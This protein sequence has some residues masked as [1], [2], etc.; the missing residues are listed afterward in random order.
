MCANKILS[1]FVVACLTLSFLSCNS[2]QDD[3]LY[4]EAVVIEPAQETTAPVVPAT[5]ETSHSTESVSREI[6]IEPE[7]QPETTEIS[8]IEPD[9][10]V[11]AEESPK[12]KGFL[13]AKGIIQRTAPSIT[14]DANKKFSSTRVL[15]PEKPMIA[16][17]FDDG[18]SDYTEDIVAKL[19][20]YDSAATFFVVG[21]QIQRYTSVLEYIVESGSEIGNHTAAH[22]Y[23]TSLNLYEIDAAI[24]DVQEK[25]YSITGIYP[26]L[27][28]PPYGSVNGFVEE[29]VMFPLILWSVDTLDWLYKDPQRI[30]DYIMENASD[31]A[32]ILMHDSKETTKEAVLITIEKLISEGFQLVTVSELFEAKNIPL[33]AGNVYRS[34]K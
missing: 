5:S 15:D 2:S 8:P 11:I 4:R 13:Y 17:T 10:P 32:V 30:S 6:F 28:R 1:F 21:T 22:A 33:E 19:N 3:V 26:T 31:S 9:A 34:A 14:D 25:V 16:L 18:P 23:L 12:I 29:S 24:M 7:I 20:E 27:V